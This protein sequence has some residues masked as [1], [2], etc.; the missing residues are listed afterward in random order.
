MEKSW[1]LY[2]KAIAESPGG[3]VFPNLT[4]ATDQGQSAE[5][6][7][8]CDTGTASDQLQC[9]RSVP[10]MKILNLTESGPDFVPAIDMAQIF[11][12]PIRNYAQASYNLNASLLIGSN[13][14]EGNFFVFA[15]TKTLQLN[16]TVFLFSISTV[17]PGFFP[18][19]FPA[20]GELLK[21][22]QVEIQA[23][24]S[25]GNYFIALSHIVGDLFISCGTELMTRFAAPFTTSG[26][27]PF[28]RYMFSHH[29]IRWELAKLNATH[30]SELPYVFDNGLIFS[31]LNSAEEQLAHRIQTYWKNFSVYGN[32]NGKA[33]TNPAES[34]PHWPEYIL[35]ENTIMEINEQSQLLS[36]WKK[37]ICSKWE[38]H[39][40]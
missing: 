3:W 19:N 37:E 20:V 35:G 23:A 38:K 29:T 40:F 25:D 18:G 34:L 1:P 13:Q 6:L 7:F 10:A 16:K 11:A 39:Y 9:M 12:Q 24:E 36:T 27:K 31:V 4:T 22:Y 15:S 33:G 26:G 32:P 2:H 21:W 8:E 28:Y 30:T 14:Q 5:S 17:L